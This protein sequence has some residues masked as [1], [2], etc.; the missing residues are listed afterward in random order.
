M[1]QKFIP[2]G[3]NLIIRMAM[4]EVVS[5]GGIVIAHEASR[6]AQA[7]EQGIIEDVGQDAFSDLEYAARQ[8]GIEPIIPKIGDTVVIARY[9]GHI[10]EEVKHSNDKH[11][12][13]VIQDTR[14]L[15]L[16]RE[17]TDE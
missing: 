12:R 16:I 7:R 6:E 15:A 5:A 1:K 13:R 11:E 3:P 9:E 4:T 2:L 10:V 8:K 14:I 17:V